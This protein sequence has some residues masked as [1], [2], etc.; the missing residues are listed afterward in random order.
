MYAYGWSYI[1]NTSHNVCVRMPETWMTASNTATYGNRDG[2][3]GLSKDKTMG[4]CMFVD[5]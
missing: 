3:C 4:L 1:S 5:V 2:T